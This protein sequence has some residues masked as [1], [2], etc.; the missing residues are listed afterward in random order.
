MLVK[1]A[2]VSIPD[3]CYLHKL[4]KLHGRQRWKDE[5]GRL[6]EWDRVHGHIEQYNSNGVHMAVLDKD[7]N[8]ID[9]AIKG[10]R[11]RL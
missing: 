6:Y 4:V 8:F 11:I 2:N 5:N 1:K 3:D 7:G 9:T 10:R